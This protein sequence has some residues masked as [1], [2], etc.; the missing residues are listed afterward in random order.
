L[1]AQ[2]P[3][4]YFD[5]HGTLDW[6]TRWK[7]ALA[8]AAADKK[9]VVVEFGR[10]ACGLCRTFVQNVMP[11]REIAPLLKKHFVALASDCDD[12]EDEVI[13]LAQNL[14]DAQM[15]PFVLFADASGK[16]LRGSSG[17]VDPVSF[18][19]TLEELAAAR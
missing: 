2:R 14:D 1:P 15:L 18:K 17:A 7:S 4:P 5:D 9:L 11:H 12:P 3:H 10:E 8:A 19:R 16:F 13:E 6:H